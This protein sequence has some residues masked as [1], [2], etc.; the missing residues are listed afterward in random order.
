M[1]IVMDV[2]HNKEAVH[3]LVKSLNHKY[4]NKE[5]IFLFGTSKKKNPNGM[6]NEIRNEIKFK[7]LN[8]PFIYLIQGNNHRCKEIETMKNEIEDLRGVSVYE[9]G[10][11]F[12]TLEFIMENNSQ[13][14]N[15]VKIIR[16]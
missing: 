15:T 6:I 11:I 14:D 5:F 7:S 12:N 2:G 16:F 10:N 8:E 1:K 13:S 3:E 9:N 4:P